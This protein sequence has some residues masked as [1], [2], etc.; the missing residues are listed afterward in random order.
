M[1]ALPE[2][3]DFLND[4]ESL[5]HYISQFPQ[6]PGT[7]LIR[8]HRFVP[9]HFH[10]VVLN[11]LFVYWGRTMLLKGRFGD[12]RD[13]GSLM[14]VTTEV[15]NSFGTSAFCTSIVTS[16]PFLFIESALSLAFL[17]WPMYSQNPFFLF[18]ISFIYFWLLFIFSWANDRFGLVVQTLMPN[19][20]L[21]GSEISTTFGIFE[22]VFTASKSI[23]FRG[24]SIRSWVGWCIYS[25]CLYS[26]LKNYHVSLTWLSLFRN[27]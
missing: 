18:F 7:Y 21:Q 9:V 12:L 3:C 20:S 23:C 6:D 13:V 8:P 4:R 22:R 26:M 27:K 17:F 25:T 11:Q 15:E 19:S 14:P 10:Q 24:S 16:F 1:V 2:H 5:D